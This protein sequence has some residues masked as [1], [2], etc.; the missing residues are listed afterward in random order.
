MPAHKA[1]GGQMH[2]L[3]VQ[4]RLHMPHAAQIQRRPARAIEDAVEIAPAQSGE[5]GVEVFGRRRRRQH[6][7]GSGGEMGVE[8][9][10]HHPGRPGLCEIQ[11]DHLTAGM[12]PGVGAARGGDAHRLAAEG[13]DRAFDL[14]LHGGQGRLGLEA[15]IRGSVILDGQTV[16]GHQASRAPRATGNPRRKSA[17]SGRTAPLPL[18]AQDPHRARAAADQQGVIE[19]HARRAL[20]VLDAGQQGLDAHRPAF[21]G[22][23]EPGAGKRREA[24][25]LAVHARRPAGPTGCGPPRA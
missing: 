2:G 19:G 17:A 8:G 4:R 16:T 6:G 14:G 10:H 5:P 15:H 13:G 20:R 22:R 1:L 12:N 9:V 11:V 25:D 24:T 23:Q 3:G 7:D 18:G 21:G